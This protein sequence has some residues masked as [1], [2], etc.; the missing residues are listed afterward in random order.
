MPKESD[1]SYYPP[2]INVED[3]GFVLAKLSGLEHIPLERD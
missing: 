1:T 3:D 2:E